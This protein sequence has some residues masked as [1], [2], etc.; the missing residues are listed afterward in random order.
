[1]NARHVNFPVD[2]LAAAIRFYSAMFASAPAVLKP[3]CAKWTLNA[4]RVSF[5][6]FTSRA[7]R[8]ATPSEPGWLLPCT[9]RPRK[10]GCQVFFTYGEDARI[11]RCEK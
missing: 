9:G 1:M 4:P 6:I 11:Q 8:C 3:D 10:S 2:D 5:T 7:S